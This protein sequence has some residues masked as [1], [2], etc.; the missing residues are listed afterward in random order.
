MGG[1]REVLEGGAIQIIM[2]DLHCCTAETKTTLQSNYIPIFKKKDND[3]SSY[4]MG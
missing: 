3:N 2:A 4:F 1:L